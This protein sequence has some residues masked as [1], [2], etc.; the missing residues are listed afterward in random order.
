M[1]GMYIF[2]IYVYIRNQSQTYILRI[3][4]EIYYVYNIGVV[5]K[6]LERKHKNVVK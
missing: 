6:K 5:K 2:I 1:Y 4:K 3:K